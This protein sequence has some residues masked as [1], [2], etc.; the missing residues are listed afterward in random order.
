MCNWPLRP[1]L[2][3]IAGPTG[4]TTAHLLSTSCQAH[5]GCLNNMHIKTQWKVSINVFLS[6]TVQNV[7]C[8]LKTT[9]FPNLLHKASCIGFQESSMERDPICT[10]PKHNGTCL[11]LVPK[12]KANTWKPVALASRNLYMLQLQIAWELVQF[13]GGFKVELAQFAAIGK[14]RG[15]ASEAN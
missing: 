2:A 13:Q 8:R 9:S 1:N 3:W 15:P 12:H 14:W 5:K 4:R 11:P 10:W 7:Q 6:N